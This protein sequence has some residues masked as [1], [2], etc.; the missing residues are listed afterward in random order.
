MQISFF[1]PVWGITELTGYE[2]KTTFWQDFSI[3]DKFGLSAVKDTF[4]RSFRDWK[5]NHIY[6][7]ELVLVLNHKCWEH[8]D[9]GNLALSGLYEE[10]FYTLQEFAVT[11]LKGAELDYFYQTT[12]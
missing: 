10:L 2:P 8:Y 4:T 9:K 3:A 12:D 1:I 7:T 11:H 6:L 5:T